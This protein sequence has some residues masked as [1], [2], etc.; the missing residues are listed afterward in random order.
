VTRARWLVVILGCVAAPGLA[1]ADEPQP[2]QQQQPQQQP[3][4][5]PQPTDVAPAPDA[6]QPSQ[7]D[8][9]APSTAELAAHVEELAEDSQ[10]K[11]QQIGRLRR[12]MTSLQTKV[13]ES[14]WLNRYINVFIDVG[15]FAVGGNG[16]GIRP[17]IGH[18]YY[19]EYMGK[20]PAEW[21][22]MGDPLSTAINTNGEPSDTST[23]R[24]IGHD[25]VNSEGHPSLIV[26]AVGLSIARQLS[27]GISASALAELLPRA[28]E[29]ILD[30]E[31]ATINYRPLT[32]KNLVFEAGKVNSVLGVEYRVQDAT[33]RKGITPSLICRYIC[34]RPLGLRGQLTDPRYS[35]SASLTN[36]NNFQQLFEHDLELKSTR[37]PTASGHVQWILPVGQ[38]LELG[39]S[40]AIGP[41][42]GQRDTSVRQWHYGFDLRVLDLH[43]FD[44]TAE[45]VHGRQPGKT[46]PPDPNGMVTECDL[47]P[48]L[49]YRGGYV[50]IDRYVTQKFI[51]YVRFDVRSA[52][53][54][55]GSDFVYES[56][57]FRT[58]AGAQFEMTD[59]LIGK[60][61]YT[62]NRELG[63]IP[64]FP[65]DVITTSL[66]LKTD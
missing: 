9:S 66:V 26:N 64:Q 16:S 47:V 56:H 17:D 5:D 57:T 50:M 41:Q 33:R 2:Q 63:R 51:P 62:Y 37:L 36:G 1:F 38:S 55:H 19:P 25:T 42:D 61:E 15:G 3:Q 48:C 60:I 43:R 24:E 45:F 65:D 54:I 44:I 13:S 35:V 58:T 32:D 28:D 8:A 22:F 30:I 40:G 39:V 23:S 18:L 49:R 4:P 6:A 59:N 20:V 21:V 12:E 14:K 31:L 10:R 52:V 34:G 11:D 7:P 53:H 46:A 27:S 29:A